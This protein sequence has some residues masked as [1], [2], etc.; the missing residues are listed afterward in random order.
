MKVHKFEIDLD[1]RKMTIE[2]G[3][4]AKQAGGSVV[5]RWGS[6][7]VLVSATSAARPSPIRAFFPLTCDYR[8][9]NVCGRLVRSPAATIKREGRMSEK[10]TLTQPHDRLETR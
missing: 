8:E 3:K 1:G 10:E 4:L 2:T 7:V 6:S 5:V 9:Y